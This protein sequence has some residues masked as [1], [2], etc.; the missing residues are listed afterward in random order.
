MGGWKPYTRRWTSAATSRSQ[1]SGGSSSKV[2]RT[3]VL[4]LEDGNARHHE[5]IAKLHG[6]RL[7]AVRGQTATPVALKP[8]PFFNLSELVPSELQDNLLGPDRVEPDQWTMLTET[9]DGEVVRLF[10][11]GDLFGPQNTECTP[12]SNGG[13]IRVWRWLHGGIDEI[14]I[15][16]VA[17]SPAR[18]R[19]PTRLHEGHVAAV[20][21]ARATR[22]L[23]GLP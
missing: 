4:P 17:R 8:R 19:I 15:S 13:A 14:R 21:R 3:G 1:H 11:N 12:G 2:G 22:P 5:L 10:H 7:N 23:K 16:N 9:Y 20:R 18:V 6:Y